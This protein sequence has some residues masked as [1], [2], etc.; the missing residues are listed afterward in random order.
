MTVPSQTNKDQQAGNGVSTVYT[1]PFRILTAA[2]LEV[3]QTIAGVTTT[4]VL[5]T[6]Y[7]VAGVGN[8]STT[9]TFVVAP[10]I[11][12]ALT[13]LRRVPLTQETDYV[14]NDPFPAE[15]HER[16][17]DKLTMVDQ[18]QQERIDAALTL[19][20]ETPPGVSATLPPPQPS[21]LFGWTP[22]GTAIQNYPFSDIATAIAYGDKLFQIFA[23][24]GAQTVFALSRD[25]GSLGNLDVSIDGVAQ[26]NGVD[27]TYVGTALTFA[28]APSNLAVILVR[29]DVA[30]PVGTGLAT[31]IQFQQAGVGAVTR[32]SQDKMR[33]RRTPEDFGA[34]GDGVIN[35]LLAIQRADTAGPFVFTMGKT[36]RVATN[37]AIAN[38]VTFEPGAKLTIDGGATVTFNGAVTA[39]SHQIFAGAG[40]ASGFAKNGILLPEWFGADPLTVADSTTA[41]QKTLAA[42]AGREVPLSGIYLI[43]SALVI[44]TPVLLRGKSKTNSG[45]KT[46]HATA[47]I[48]EVQC[49]A[50]PL[51]GVEIRDIVLD[52]TAAKSAGAGIAVL[53]SSGGTLYDGVIQ[54]IYMT[55]KM[56]SGVRVQSAF[57]LRLKDINIVKIGSNGVGLN[58]LGVDA[59]SKV[60]NVYIDTCTVRSGTAGG[61]TIGML[62]DSYCEGFTIRDCYFESNGLNYGVYINNSLAAP[63][64]PMNLWFN[65][66]VC[67][68]NATHGWNILA[69]RTLRMTDTWS[70]SCGMNG[71]SLVTGIDVEIRGHSAIGNGNYG[72][73]IQATSK[74]VR[75]IGGVFDANGQ[76]A[77]NT[78][79][80]IAVNSNTTDFTIVDADFFRQGTTKTHKYDVEIIGGTSDRYIIKN[81]RLRGFLTA[82]II[83]GGAGVNKYV[84]ENIT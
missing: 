69:A 48:I 4:L 56:F 74:Q 71:V 66:V 7:A 23:G 30:V 29:F 77:A 41:L 14:P 24:T 46:N 19:A 75:I 26:V 27:F 8:P 58:F 10:A 12:T 28:V 62:I 72:V 65:S 54:N 11:G 60:V 34:V 83:D 81:N 82:G 55:D 43:S 63:N 44:S 40:T 79:S 38:N 50:S 36:Y 5:T 32:S 49:G 70:V 53:A 2:H 61:N 47:N 59:I 76:A 51:T 22:D 68:N 13:F 16:A 80:G 52:A 39:G 6:D 67:D 73:A 57:F 25:P 64:P 84:N 45:F 21:T 17:L 78:Y 15:S 31:A 3:L 35:D 20:P 18:Q 37:L 42:A 1:V 33:E 9:V